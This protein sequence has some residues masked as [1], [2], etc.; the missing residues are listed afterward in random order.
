MLAARRVLAGFPT[1]GGQFAPSDEA[2]VLRDGPVGLASQAPICEHLPRLNSLE[3]RRCV[4]DAIEDRS[5]RPCRS[6]LTQL[7]S[8]PNTTH[9][10]TGALSGA[11]G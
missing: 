3:E 1:S 2:L 8:M 5:K 7:V 9:Q 6:R 10:P 11:G 4:L